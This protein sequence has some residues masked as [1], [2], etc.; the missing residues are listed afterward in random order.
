MIL[1]V[2]RQ[3]LFR[4]SS[5]S[6][7]FNWQNGQRTQGCPCWMWP[8]NEA[9]PAVP[10]WDV[11]TGKEVHYPGPGWHSRVHPGWGGP[12]PPGESGRAY[13]P[14]LFSN[15]SK[16]KETRTL[17]S[18]W[19]EDS[20]SYAVF[21]NSFIC[22]LAHVSLVFAVWIMRRDAI[23]SRLVTS[24]KRICWAFRTHYRKV[25]LGKAGFRNTV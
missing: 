10:R 13:G 20:I 5:P 21:L 16:V 12:H 11:G 17:F 7:S 2:W 23:V 25:V 24:R 18:S 22:E 6:V 1:S 9:V 4:T 15:H 3:A 8:C 19:S 14:E